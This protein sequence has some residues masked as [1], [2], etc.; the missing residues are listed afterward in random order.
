MKIMHILWGLKYGGA[1]TMLIDIINR[2]CQNHAIEVLLIND[3]IDE[4]LLKQIDSSITIRRINRPLKTKN[5]FYIVELN[6]RILFSK[7]DIIH[8]HQENIIRYFPFRFLKQNLCLTVHSTIMDVAEV[9][10]FKFVFAIS[11]KV[12]EE[13][14]RKTG[15]DAILIPNGTDIHTFNKK[16]NY[17]SNCFK[18]VQIGRLNHL[19]KGQHIAI[20]ALSL[21]VHKQSCRNVHL[22]LIGNGDSENYLRELSYQ[23]NMDSYITFVGNQSQEYLREHLSS[24]DLLVQPSII[25]GFGLTVLEAMAAMVPTL[26]S[27]VD[28]M[29]MITNNG[30]L[31]YT[32]QSGDADDLARQI[33][34][35]IKLT[36]NDR[37]ELASKAYDYVFSHFDIA[38]TAN[39]YLKNYEIIL[40]KIKEKKTL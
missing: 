30:K 40:S 10:Q 8:F 27:N 34:F 33:V 12:Q 14:L 35:I 17:H 15:K 36:E 5:V 3:D 9:K 4:N 7:V 18:I 21:L 26:I 20:K 32:F 6:C 25:E 2:Q 31:A 13:I 39:N 22:Y 16:D 37:K 38:I 28:G 11:N 19:Q 24:Y 29:Q 23:L 1:E